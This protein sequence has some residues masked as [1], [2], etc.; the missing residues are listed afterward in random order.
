M[1][2]RQSTKEATMSVFVDEVVTTKK[3]GQY[4]VMIADEVDE[5]HAIASKIGLGQE[6][7]K[8]SPPNIIPCYP[9]D[10]R[11][12]ELACMHGALDCVRS[13]KN[14][15]LAEDVRKWWIKVMAKRIRDNR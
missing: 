11:Q 12:R 8:P 4:F 5:L 3:P 6:Y 7:F 2:N 13:V 1:E 9:L 10:K 14:F 15:V